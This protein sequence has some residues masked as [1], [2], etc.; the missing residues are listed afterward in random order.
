VDFLSALLADDELRPVVDA[1]A[2]SEVGQA[3]VRLPV[4]AVL[5]PQDREQS[6]VLVDGQELAVA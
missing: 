4:A 2:S 3:E 5:R 6:L 1:D